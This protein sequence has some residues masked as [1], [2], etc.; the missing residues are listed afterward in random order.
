M[1]PLN[2]SMG[3]HAMINRMDFKMQTP[4][5]QPSADELAFN[6]CLA[7]NQEDLDS[8]TDSPIDNRLYSHGRQESRTP[9]LHLV[10]PD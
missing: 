3:I 8:I 10:G 9:S 1:A 4:S 7:W 6:S 5:A 2:S